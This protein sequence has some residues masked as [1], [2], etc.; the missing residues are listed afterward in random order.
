LG[1]P[2]GGL[3]GDKALKPQQ[4]KL[5]PQKGPKQSQ[6][7]SEYKTTEPPNTKQENDSWS[8]TPKSSSNF[9]LLLT[10]LAIKSTI[11]TARSLTTPNLKT[12]RKNSTNHF[13]SDTNLIFSAFE[14]DFSKHKPTTGK[15]A[16]SIP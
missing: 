6:I 2:T 16:F 1:D 11:T 3:R 7:P 12:F 14:G 8:F 4:P 15:K 5:Q 10:L 13:A 9:R